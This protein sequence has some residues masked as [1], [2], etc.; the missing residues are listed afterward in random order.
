MKRNSTFTT[1]LSSAMSWCSIFPPT[2][3]TASTALAIS[4]L[5]GVGSV[6]VGGLPSLS[7]AGFLS[8][9]PASLVFLPPSELRGGSVVGALL[10]PADRN[11]ASAR[12]SRVADFK[13]LSFQSRRAGRSP[14]PSYPRRPAP[15]SG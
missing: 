6:L 2:F 7:P 12:R 10:Q 15:A 3:F 11:R 1:G 4:S 13:G 9:S 8:P 5:V 14:V